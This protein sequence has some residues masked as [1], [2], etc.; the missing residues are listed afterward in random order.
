MSGKQPIPSIYQLKIKLEGFSPPIWRRMLVS[1]DTTLFNLHRIIQI[2]FDWD[3]DHLH[4]FIGIKGLDYDPILFDELDDTRDE[5]TVEDVFTLADAA[6]EEKIK[7]R[8]K[9]DFGALWNH[10]ILVEKILPPDPNQQ[11][12]ICIKGKRAAPPEYIDFEDYASEDD[13]LVKLLLDPNDPNN[14]QV[15]EQLPKEKFDPEFFDLDA[16]NEKLRPLN[17]VNNAD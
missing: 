9:Y 8:Y 10:V 13:E 1:G 17:T 3:G 15:E 5:D 11:L 2:L 14:P 12:P 7:F 16:I 6:P 4:L